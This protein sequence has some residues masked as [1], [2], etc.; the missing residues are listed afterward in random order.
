MHDTL[1]WLVRKHAEE[2]AWDPEFHRLLD[3]NRWHITPRP[4]VFFFGDELPA[5]TLSNGF[6]ISCGLAAPKCTLDGRNPSWVQDPAIAQRALADESEYKTAPVNYNIDPT[7]DLAIFANHVKSKGSKPANRIG[8][9]WT[10][11]NWFSARNSPLPPTNSIY[12]L[13]SPLLSLKDF[14]YQ[15]DIFSNQT[16]DRPLIPFTFIRVFQSLNTTNYTV[17]NNHLPEIRIG[18][19][20]EDNMPDP[21][22]KKTKIV[23]DEDETG[24]AKG[25]G[26][27]GVPKGSGKGKGKT[28]SPNNI[29]GEEY[30]FSDLIPVD[31]IWISEGTPFIFEHFSKFS[32]DQT[33]VT[34]VDR[35]NL[36]EFVTRVVGTSPIAIILG[37]EVSPEIILE[38]NRKHVLKSAYVNNFVMQDPIAK[39][40]IKPKVTLIAF[41]CPHVATSNPKAAVTLVLPDTVEM[42]IEY[43]GSDGNEDAKFHTFWQRILSKFRNLDL[44]STKIYSFRETPVGSTCLMRISKDEHN[45]LYNLSGKHDLYASVF[46]RGTKPT[47]THGIVWTTPKNASDAFDELSK[48]EG[49]LGLIPP[50]KNKQFGVRISAE[51]LGGAR[52]ILLKDMPRTRFNADNLDIVGTYFFDLEGFPAESTEETVLEFGKQT[53]WSLIPCK[54][55]ARRNIATWT[56][57]TDTKPPL[58]RFCTS[59]GPVIVH[60]VSLEPASSSGA[61]MQIDARE[62]PELTINKEHNRIAESIEQK[63]QH[64]FDQLTEFIKTQQNM[65]KD[66]QLLKGLAEGL[67]QLPTV[68]QQF[69]TKLQAEQ[70]SKLNELKG[71][72]KSE[73]DVTRAAVGSMQQSQNSQFQKLET[74]LT[75]WYSQTSTDKA[76]SELEM[77]RLRVS[78]DNLSALGKHADPESLSPEHKKT[79]TEHTPN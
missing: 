40:S 56:I 13:V 35:L 54:K 60:G 10:S 73:Q 48:I 39:L 23:F 45:T 38:L 52:V 12:S 53:S 20:T 30:K 6:Q 8:K 65:Q 17:D 62:L 34:T 59:F 32:H 3:V 49:F 36:T 70:D 78:V 14:F 74:L 5:L 42:L 7:S 64:K 43:R 72:I 18:M 71:Q 4:S 19:E 28:K 37:G 44:D 26:T 22:A 15:R 46:Y 41:N 57:R 66:V 51:H 76:A 25:K 50:N 75:T 58:S 11:P 67:Q 24:K 33:A 63:Y 47:S 21:W 31:P 2:T 27:G 77:Q 55:V 16:I 69:E 79:R 68:L 61:R 1:D 9:V 29:R